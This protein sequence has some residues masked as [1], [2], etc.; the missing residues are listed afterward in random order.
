MNAPQRIETTGTLENLATEINA[1]HRA[2]EASSASVV[3]HAV[4]A[5]EMLLGVKQSLKHG[6]WLKW[7]DANFEGSQQTASIY[8]RFARRQAELNYQRVGNLSLRGA[9][10]ALETDDKH[11]KRDT[12]REERLEA[13]KQLSLV[14][15]WC[16]GDWR[17]YLPALEDESVSLLLTDPPYG[18]C[19]RSNRRHV[20]HDAIENDDEIAAPE[21][22]ADMLRVVYPK[23]A[24]DAH[25]VVFTSPRLERRFLDAIEGA[26]YALR[27]YLVWQKDN[28]GSGDLEGTFAPKH[29]RLIHATKGSAKM[30]RRTDDVLTYPRVS[31]D[32]HPTQKP[33]ALLKE[34]IEALTV[35]GE[36]VLDP[37]GGVASTLVA[38]EDCGRRGLGC[39]IDA[40]YHTF[41]LIRL[42][43]V[44]ET[45]EVA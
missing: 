31:S 19:Y 42:A 9:M 33:V 45:E 4:R 8:M 2:C 23:L 43:D 12:L 30:V 40:H 7:L 1:E 18:I 15:N 38:A 11:R 3:E 13:A 10:R 26:G 27:S 41:G 25:V 22:L 39:E 14:D 29:E 17:D 36:A 16:H 34:I 20:L 35:E 5:G 28:H 32:D 44:G 37:Y 24:R 6:G 21:N